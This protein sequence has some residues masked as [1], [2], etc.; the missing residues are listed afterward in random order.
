VINE[1]QGLISIFHVGLV[2]PI[3]LAEAVLPQFSQFFF[4]KGQ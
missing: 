3:E 1:A 2:T 4:T